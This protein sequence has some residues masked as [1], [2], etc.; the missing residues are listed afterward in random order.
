MKHIWIKNEAGSFAENKDTAKR[1]RL[2]GIIPALNAGDEVNLDF[3]GV[4][5]V[6]QSF[7]HALISDVIRKYGNP[8]LDRVT[9]KSCNENVRKIIEMVTD[10]TQEGMGD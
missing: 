1:L 4:E 8:V 5:A 3:K 9:F 6:T 2:E 10:Y 7:I